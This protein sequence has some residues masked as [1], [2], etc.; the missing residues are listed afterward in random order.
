MLGPM[1]KGGG[2]PQVQPQMQPTQA[3]AAPMGKGGATTQQMP[4][5]GGLAALFANNQPAVQTPVPQIS[6]PSQQV[7]QITAPQYG[8]PLAPSPDQAMAATRARMLARTPPPP[9][10]VSGPTPEQQRQQRID[11]WN[12]RQR[13]G[14]SNR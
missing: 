12:N 11:D 14:G 7:P 5:G 2:T 6:A 10:P 13:S 1:D 3:G 8:P 9:A 4:P